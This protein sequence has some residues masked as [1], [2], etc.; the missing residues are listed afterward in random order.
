MG[1]AQRRRVEGNFVDEDVLET[2]DLNAPGVKVD[3]GD[4]TALAVARGQHAATLA[5]RHQLRTQRGA[6]LLAAHG[7]DCLLY[8]S[9][10]V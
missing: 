6:D 1:K 3:L 4:E 2:T 5:N 7:I 8:T 10:C 9:R